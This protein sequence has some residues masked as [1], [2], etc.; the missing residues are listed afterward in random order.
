MLE[1][2]MKAQNYHKT[3]LINKEIMSRIGHTKN[4]CQYRSLVRD[5]VIDTGSYDISE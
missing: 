4:S 1:S 5:P 2:K 3:D